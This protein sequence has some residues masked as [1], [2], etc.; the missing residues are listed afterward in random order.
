MKKGNPKVLTG[1]KVGGTQKGG[2]LKMKGD[3]KPDT[4]GKKQMKAPKNKSL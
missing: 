3:Y 2:G 4:F 1:V